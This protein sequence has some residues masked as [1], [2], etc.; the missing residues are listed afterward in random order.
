MTKS[1]GYYTVKK[2][3]KL[4]KEY[5]GVCHWNGCT[6]KKNLQ[7][8]HRFP[9]KVSGKGRG[10][11]IRFKDIIEH[12]LNYTLLCTIHHIEF[13]TM[14]QDVTDKSYLEPDYIDKI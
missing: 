9:T 10:S 6:T 4:R 2:I 3:D 13:D 12:P 14:S 1:G 7:F 11:W 5:G 8:A